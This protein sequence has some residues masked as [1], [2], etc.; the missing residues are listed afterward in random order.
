MRSVVAAVASVCLC[1][2]GCD[3]V[4]P[5]D[6]PSGIAIDRNLIGTWRDISE[7]AP[8]TNDEGEMIVR[9]RTDT[10]YLIHIPDKEEP[11]YYR[12]YPIKVAGISCIQI[13][14]LGTSETPKAPVKPD[15]FNVVTC[16]LKGDKLVVNLLDYDYVSP[17][18]AKRGKKEFQREFAK[19]KDRKDL[20]FKCLELQ[21]KK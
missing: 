14:F 17:I 20:F 8:K 10:E 2:V 11:E 19:N 4:A 6:E 18:Y 16:D 7:G 21:R 15:R 3:Y 9:K 12:A 5:L 1:I 13:E